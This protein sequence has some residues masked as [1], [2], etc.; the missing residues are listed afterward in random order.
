[1]KILIVNPGVQPELQQVVNSLSEF[2]FQVRYATA[3]SLGSEFFTISL[4]RYAI[5]FQSIQKIILRRKLN[6]SEKLI[7]RRGFFLELISFAL[8][9]FF[10]KHIRPI[11]NFY[12][13]LNLFFFILVWNP[14]IIVYQDKIPYIYKKL[15]KSNN[16]I[17]ILVV[18]TASP[19]Y[20]SEIYEKEFSINQPWIK[21]FPPNG[22]SHKE[23]Q[24]YLADCKFA[25]HIMV[26]SKFVIRD[27]S[28][29][30]DRERIDVI[31]LGYSLASLGINDS[32][33]TVSSPKKKNFKVIFV[34]QLSQRKGLGYLIEGFLKAK[35]PL[36]STLTLVGTSVLGSAEYIRKNISSDRIEVVG[37]VN[38]NQLG[39]LLLEHDLFLMPSLI[40]GFC[41]SAVEALGTGI[42]V[43]ITDVVLDD[44]V[45]DKFNGYILEK[46][47][48]DSIAM[49]L[50]HVY[51]FPI[52]AKQ[53]G[54][55]GKQLASEF[56]WE[57]YSSE[58]LRV[59]SN[60]YHNRYE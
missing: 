26:P 6:F 27:L 23:I 24:R 13:Y 17:S 53:V 20:F 30:I 59:L 54:L 8:L 1:M 45:E 19:M 4:V 21:F 34:G 10:G 40:E 42:P 9:R 58:F 36:S 22:F 55:N 44:I 16:R 7:F 51:N 2:G 48:S 33:H 60:V 5:R 39:P 14:R 25:D 18:S 46:H 43:A 11:R 32:Y 15:L 47:S 41:L 50:E 35:I 12:L 3:S 57:N 52:E 49:I 38:R 37:H 29:F 28:R 31:H 56:T